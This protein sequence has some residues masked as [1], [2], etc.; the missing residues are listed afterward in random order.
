MSISDRLDEIEADAQA[1]MEDRPADPNAVELAMKVPSVLAALRAERDEWKAR[2]EQAE[3]DRDEAQMER[4]DALEEL[5]QA[6]SASEVTRDDIEKALWACQ[7]SWKDVTWGRIVDE[8]MG[9]VMP[10][11]SGDD[12]AVYVVRESKVKAQDALRNRFGEFVVNGT[13]LN[14]TTAE[15]CREKAQR[16]LDAV[17]RCESIAR[18]IEAE[19]TNGERSNE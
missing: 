15:D 5:A 4:S 9:A 11:V 8:V 2:A 13:V 19:L 3:R 14:V 18:A 7:G 12:P 10:L 6:K 1:C 16:H 17:A